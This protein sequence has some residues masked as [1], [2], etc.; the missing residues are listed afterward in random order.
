MSDERWE[1]EEEESEGGTLRY[2][3]EHK[4]Y[5]KY[6][7]STHRKWELWEDGWVC[8]H[9]GACTADEYMQIEGIEPSP[10]QLAFFQRYGYGRGVYCQ[11]WYPPELDEEQAS[12]QEEE[13]ERS[14]QE[15]ED[16]LLS[17]L[18]ADMVEK[19]RGRG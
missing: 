13:E 6:C 15:E 9:C 14:E 10:E 4:A 7:Y 11:R 2:D 18:L 5:C 8:G 1:N 19:Q 12:E 17:W 16:R 3:G